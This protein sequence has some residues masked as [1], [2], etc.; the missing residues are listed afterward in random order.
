MKKKEELNLREG[1]ES[2]NTRGLAVAKNERERE[3][4]RECANRQ[5]NR[6]GQSKKDVDET[7]RERHRERNCTEK[8]QGEQIEQLR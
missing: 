8:E 5:G 6:Q 7:K 3:T 2:E 1:R 4:T